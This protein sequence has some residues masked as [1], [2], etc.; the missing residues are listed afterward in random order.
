MSSLL[1][2][3]DWKVK[4]STPFFTK[5]NVP[6]ALLSHHKHRGWRLRPAVR[7]GGHGHLLRFCQ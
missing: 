3:A 1:I 7:H 4:R 2:P 6:A 5:E